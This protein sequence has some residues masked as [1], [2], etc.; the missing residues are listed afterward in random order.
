MY[1]I[2]VKLPPFTHQMTLEELFFGTYKQVHISTSDANTRTYAVDYISNRFRN[3][4]DVPHLL[5]VLKNFNDS[6]EELRK[7]DRHKLYREFSIPKKSGGLRKIAAPNDEL[8]LA[9]RRLKEIFEV[10][11]GALYHT[12]AFAY[13]KHRSTVDCIKRHQQNESKWFAKFDLSNFFGSTTIEYVMKMLGMVFPFCLLTST[14]EGYK[15]LYKAVE[16]AFL[17]GG[18]PQGTPISPLITNIIMIP[19]DYYLSNTL[20]DYDKKNFIYT[21]YA[22]DFQISC[23]YDFNFRDIENLIKT[24]LNDFGAPFNINEKKSRYGSSAGKNYNLG[25]MLNS[26]NE[27]T[28]G[29]KKKKAFEAM[30]FNYAKDKCNNIK[31]S[32]EDIQTLE[33]LRNYYTMIE[34]ETINRII[35]HLSNKTEIDI[36][37]SIRKDLKGVF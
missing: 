23:K 6:T 16:L 25:I 35:K 32:L 15:E 7:E 30:L 11:F 20:R 36:I 22:D 27:M 21:R 5:Y 13:I 17:D 31:W 18:L 24:S 29:H 4:I 19:V 33:G 28:I 26:K 1:Y 12:A 9:L 10:E 2:T 8:M 3:R 14:E 34:G 37:D